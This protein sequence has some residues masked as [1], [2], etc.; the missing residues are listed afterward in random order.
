[1]LPAFNT[2]QNTIG[3]GK[4]AFYGVIYP[5]IVATPVYGYLGGAQDDTAYAIS[6]RS[7]QEIWIGGETRSADFPFTEPGLAGPSDAFI[8]K[9]TTWSFVV[10]QGS[11]PV[12]AVKISSYRI[13]G[14]G[15]DS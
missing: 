10:P 15:E 13:G 12:P 1:D 9:I 14:N 4:D 3:G 11:Q 2:P 7:F 5:N 6:I 8:A